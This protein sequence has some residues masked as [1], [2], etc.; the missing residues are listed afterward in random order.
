MADVREP[1]FDV[2]VF[3]TP[4]ELEKADAW[5]HQILQLLFLENG[6]YEHSP[7]MG[8]ELN[9]KKYTEINQYCQYIRDEIINQVNKWLPDIPLD[10]VEVSKYYWRSRNTDIVMIGLWF[11]E[12]GSIVS[13]VAYIT[14]KDDILTYIIS[15]FNE[16]TK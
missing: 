11:N 12:D 9:A 6:T 3:D 16:N 1:S 2:S 4:L 8:V 14:T 7:E 15:K 13:R 5:S 10:R